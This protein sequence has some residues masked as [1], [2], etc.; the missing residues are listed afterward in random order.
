M[1][2]TELTGTLL[3]TVGILFFIAMG[4]QIM[5]WKYAIFSGVACLMLAATIRRIGRA[6]KAT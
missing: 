2:W 6:R 4:F 5:S 1:H 3:T